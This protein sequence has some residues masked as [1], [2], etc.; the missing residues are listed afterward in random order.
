MCSSFTFGLTE[1]EQT[2]QLRTGIAVNWCSEIS[3]FS[4]KSYSTAFEG[5]NVAHLKSEFFYFSA[6]EKQRRQKAP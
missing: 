1:S 6:Q 2:L 3:D 4:Y 5:R